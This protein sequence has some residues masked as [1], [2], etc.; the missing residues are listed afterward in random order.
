MIKIGIRQNLIYPTAFAFSSAL[1]DI[2]Y[3]IMKKMKENI[4]KKNFI[5]FENLF[6]SLIIFI[7]EF[8][9]GLIFYKYHINFLKR[10]KIETDSTIMGIKLVKRRNVKISIPDSNLVIY[11]YIFLISLLD[12]SDFFFKINIFPNYYNTSNISISSTLYIRLRVVLTFFSSFFSYFLLKIPIHKHQKCSLILLGFCFLYFLITEFSFSF[13]KHN[14]ID[15]KFTFIIVMTILSQL[16]FSFIDI[17]EKYLLEYNFVNPFQMLMI[18]G[19]FGAILVIISFF[20]WTNPIYEIKQLY[21]I[22]KDNLLIIFILILFLII[23]L[24]LSGIK[25]IYRVVTNKIYNPTTKNLFDVLFSPLL[26]IIYFYYENDYQIMEHNHHR[27]II[28]ICNLFISF[29]IVF[30]CCVY[31]E[32]FVLFCCGLEYNTHR[33]ISKR[34]ELNANLKELN[35][36]DDD[37]SDEGE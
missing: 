26:L 22:Y 4:L 35:P 9:S 30:S 7:S 27:T 13:L 19:I 16:L 34:A 31:N 6:L 2:E 25:N 10:R 17:I 24:V 18:E 8:I 12:Y 14:S 37:D 20:I 36:A 3:I 15:P 1:R 29:L 23:Y 33:E 21:C 11:I 28:F 5:Y 32:L